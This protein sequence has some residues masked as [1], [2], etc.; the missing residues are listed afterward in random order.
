MMSGQHVQEITASLKRN[1]DDRATLVVPVVPPM[2]V[3]VGRRDREYREQSGEQQNYDLF[4]FCSR[5]FSLMDLRWDLQ[6]WV[7]HAMI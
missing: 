1:Y 4:H 7:S 2:V 5:N 3:G 6:L